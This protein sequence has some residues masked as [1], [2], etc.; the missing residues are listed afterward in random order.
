M[1]KKRKILLT[2]SLIVVN[3]FLWGLISFKVIDYILSLDGEETIVEIDD[4]VVYK[5]ASAKNTPVSRTKIEYEKL[6]RDPFRIYSKPVVQKPKQTAKKIPPIP[7]A[8]F[9]YNLNGIIENNNNRLAIFQDTKNGETLFLRAGETKNEIKVKKIT[10]T[11][12]VV[13]FNREEKVIT[14]QK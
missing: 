13:I 3:V 11:E 14:V 6:E 5:K 2:I 12:V 4:T 10:E 8:E 9:H 1:K 7:A